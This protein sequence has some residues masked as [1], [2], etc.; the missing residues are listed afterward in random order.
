MKT[1]NSFISAKLNLRRYFLK[2]YPSA[3]YR[4]VDCY[5]GD[6]AIW[7]RLGQ[8]YPIQ[9]IG[10]D[11]NKASDGVIN[12]AAEKWLSQTEWLAD[13]VD[14][15]SKKDPWGAYFALLE[16]F[17]GD[18][19]TV[20][21]TSI[22]CSFMSKLVKQQVGIPTH[23][24]VGYPKFSELIR[25]A[26]LSHALECGFEVL[27][28]RQIVFPPDKSSPKLFCGGLRLKWLN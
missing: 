7:K 28:A 15:D 25:G 19:I 17:V 1:G 8:E 5:A 24:K 26:C 20:F 11:K 22:D 3:P 21:L 10:L 9:Y 27:E 12:I 2:K 13:V 23:W 18:E 6:Q 16:N 4:V 14:I